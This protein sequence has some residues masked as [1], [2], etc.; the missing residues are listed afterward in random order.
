M[1]HMKSGVITTMAMMTHSH[2]R[3]CITSITASTTLL[4]TEHH[5]VTNTLR[6]HRLLA[7]C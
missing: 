1:T 5:N 7:F 6:S 4:C 3:S 2:G